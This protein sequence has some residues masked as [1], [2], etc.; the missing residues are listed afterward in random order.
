MKPTRV[1]VQDRFFG[2]HRAL[3]SYFDQVQGDPRGADP[4]RFCWDFWHVPG[5][6]RLLRTPA[7]HY[8]PKPLYDELHQKLV[9]FGREVL[10]C[11]DISPPWMSAYIDGCEQRFHADLPHGPWA[12]VYSLS[13]GEGIRGG[14]TLLLREQTLSLWEQPGP[15]AG[16]GMESAD[17]LEAIR[18]VANRL[19]VF[20]P[21][22]PHGVARVEGARDLLE[23]RVV[24]HGWFV[25]P[26][27]FIEGRLPARALSREISR[28][29]EGLDSFFRLPENDGASVRGMV[30]V[31]FAVGPSGRVA[32]PRVLAHSL[33]SQ[34]EH[35]GVVD[36]L[37]ARILGSLRQSRFD[38]AHAGSKVTLP[39]VFD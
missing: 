34:G 18:P 20:D 19:T 6:Y 39:L 1:H 22:I 5:Q 10:G 32:S 8:F 27:P 15:V 23:A 24:I 12:F 4:R 9:K 21:R 29:L 16:A 2:G 13:P 17:V 35:E 37:I 38:A 11:H 7:Y 31:K 3:K 14:E 36:R 25:Q 33:R 26:R 28:V 30:S